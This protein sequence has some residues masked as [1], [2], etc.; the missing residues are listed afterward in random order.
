MKPTDLGFL[1]KADLLAVGSGFFV[2]LALSAV[3]SFFANAK[4]SESGASQPISFNH[5]LH[6]EDEGLEC[7]A[8][9]SYYERETFS[10]L[11][12]MNACVLCHSEMQGES[13]AEE[14]L[15]SAIEDGTAIEWA[16]LFRQPP[17]VFF[18]HRL[19][20]VVAEIECA[21]CHGDIGQ[22]E[23]PPTNPRRLSM[24]QCIACHEEHGIAE[25]CGSC[26]R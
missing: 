9:H 18:S 24:D 23:E 15:V 4:Y 13:A 2:L 20:V 6:V 25:S 17:H 11:P 5:R 14:K 8:C 26:H 21:T 22:S 12:S 7:S 10:G 1:V 3:V 16:P 19:H